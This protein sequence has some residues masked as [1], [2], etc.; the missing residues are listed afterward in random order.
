METIPGKHTRGE[1]LLNIYKLAIGD[2]LHIIRRRRFRKAVALEAACLHWSDQSNFG[3]TYKP[4]Y[5][6][7]FTQDIEWGPIE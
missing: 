1:V 2:E 4:R 3:V 7:Y 6:A 5:L